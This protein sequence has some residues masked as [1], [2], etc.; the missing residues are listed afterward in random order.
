MPY[1]A[2]DGALAKA[3]QKLLIGNGAGGTV[4][5]MKV[6]GGDGSTD[7]LIWEAKKVF[8]DEFEL[9]N[10]YMTSNWNV[11]GT[12]PWLLF[13]NGGAGMCFG[14]TT[15]GNRPSQGVW[16]EETVTW[17]QYCKAELFAAGSTGLGTWLQ[18]HSREDSDSYMG[19]QWNDSTLTLFNAPGG[20]AATINRG[21]ATETRVAGKVFELRAE[22]NPTTGIFTYRALVNNVQKITWT[23]SSNIIPKP[24]TNKKCGWGSRT[25]RSFGSTKYAPSLAWWEAGDI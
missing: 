11:I 3:F 24:S 6:M 16:K 20:G 15:D 2:G 12:S 21:T 19:L 22:Q 17:N 13:Q 8:R 7:R 1:I 9:V 5:I 10:S 18:V 4:P 23:D 25:N 14:N